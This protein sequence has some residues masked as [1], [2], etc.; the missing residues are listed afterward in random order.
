[1][2]WQ[3][4]AG[5]AVSSNTTHWIVMFDLFF[6]EYA[7]RK[8]TKIILRSHHIVLSCKNLRFQAQL[9]SFIIIS[10]GMSAGRLEATSLSSVCCIVGPSLSRCPFIWWPQWRRRRSP[11]SRSHYWDEQAIGCGRFFL[12]RHSFFTSSSFVR[13]VHFHPSGLYSAGLVT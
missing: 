2:D 12:L 1:M 11:V 13:S 6:K 5:F 4:K 8:T 3:I 7:F 10:K 9:Q